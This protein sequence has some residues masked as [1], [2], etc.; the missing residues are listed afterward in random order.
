VTGILPS[1]G[2]LWKLGESFCC[3]VALAGVQVGLLFQSADMAQRSDKKKGR[4]G[5][6]PGTTFSRKLL[7]LRPY[8][9]EHLVLKLGTLQ[10]QRVTIMSHP[11]N[12]RMVSK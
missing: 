12:T 6:H 2:F 10:R 4:P 8:Q 9:P 7:M 5:Y 3:R 11:V 1:R